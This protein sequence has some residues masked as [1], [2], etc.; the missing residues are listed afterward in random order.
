LGIP[1]QNGLCVIKTKEF[2]QPMVLVDVYGLRPELAEI[3]TLIHKESYNF[4]SGIY[5]RNPQQP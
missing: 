3:I 5:V 4:L 1:D 2:T